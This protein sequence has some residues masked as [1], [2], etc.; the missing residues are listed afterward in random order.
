MIATLSILV[1]EGDAE[2][3]SEV[4]DVLRADGHTVHLA[5]ESLSARVHARKHAVDA[6]VIEMRADGSSVELARYLRSQVL[7]VG[8]AIVG[9]GMLEAAADPHAFDASLPDSF[10][11]NQ[12]SGL[13]HH[14][15]MIRRV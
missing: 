14:L 13:I 9:Y 11:V 4:L 10:E 15:R 7:P 8:S 3:A 6:V 1:V 5:A 12:L 2:R